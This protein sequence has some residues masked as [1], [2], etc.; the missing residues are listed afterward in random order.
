ML[1]ELVLVVGL[2]VS[3]HSGVR[4]EDPD[5][6]EEEEEEQKLGGRPRGSSAAHMRATRTPSEE[7]REREI[8]RERAWRG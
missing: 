7:E 8:E 1:A 5:V 3:S 2:L 4:A 6:V